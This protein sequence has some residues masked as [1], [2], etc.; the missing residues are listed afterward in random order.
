[1]KPRLQSYYWRQEN[2]VVNLG[3]Y[4]TEVIVN[5]FGYQFVPTTRISE[6]A[7]LV[8][9][10]RC[11][12]ACGSI[13]DAQHVSNVGELSID[14]WGSGTYTN[15]HFSERERGRLS[16]HA[17]RGPLSAKLLGVS[18]AL[19]MGDPALLLPLFLK[20]PAVCSEKILYVPHFWN[21]SVAKLRKMEKQPLPRPKRRRLHG[22]RT[23]PTLT[24]WRLNADEIV[25]TAI[26]R[27][28]WKHCVETIASAK[29]V[30][31]GSLHGAILAQAYGVPWALALPF[32][33]P[34]D[35]PN[36]WKDWFLYL[37]IEANPK[38]VSNFREGQLW[39]HSV[40]RHGAIRDLRPLVEAFP[41]PFL[42]TTVPDA[43]TIQPVN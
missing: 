33:A 17:L 29:F 12:F 9:A 11:L 34:F 26:V 35:K 24:R 14:I 1:M 13:I 25:D 18:E 6:D 10:N 39:W 41:Y 43:C 37:G 27:S 5:A 3:D 15:P 20:K 16:Y 40:G 36:K 31:T 2:E 42:D 7:D 22:L 8:A 23:D 32:R 30:L 4:L 38:A 28:E 19:P 21:T